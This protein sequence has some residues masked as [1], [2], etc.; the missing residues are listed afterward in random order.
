[1]SLGTARDALLDDARRQAQEIVAAGEAEADQ[2]L[3]AARRDA[4][5]LLARARA[6]GE[7]EGRRAAIRAQ[8]RQRFGAHMQVLAARRASYDALAQ[9]AR[10]D[11]LALRAE[12]GYPQLLELLTA[13]ARAD[14]GADAEV[15]VDPPGLGGVI[16]R[17]GTRAVDYTL[18]AIA[19]RCVQDLGPRV[20]E[21]WS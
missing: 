15:T 4:D 5:E 9:R 2:R 1:M 13:A 20:A 3:R 21:L 19:E 12:P 17:A 6:E 10:A 11:A 7:A 18:V 8:A 14:L 16:A